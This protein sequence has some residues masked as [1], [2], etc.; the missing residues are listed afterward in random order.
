LPRREVE[1]RDQH[2]E[3]ASP[4]AGGPD[5]PGPAED[6]VADK[7]LPGHAFGQGLGP[8]GW[9]EGERASAANRGEFDLGDEGA[10]PGPWLIVD[11]DAV[12][13]EGGG[14][15]VVPERGL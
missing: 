3:V 5:C 15:L 11:R 9:G 8:A 13:A 2:G 14:D 7:R 1:G 6:G 4:C 10:F 12:R